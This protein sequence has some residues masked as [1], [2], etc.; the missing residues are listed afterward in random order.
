MHFKLRPTLRHAL[1]AIM[2]P[3]AVAP[4]VTGCTDEYIYDD[5]A[6][7][8]LGESIY[9]ELQ[10]R[11]SFNTMLRLIEDLGY[12]EVLSKTGSKTLFVATDDAFE[13]FFRRNPFG[14]SSYEDLSSAQKRLIMNTSMINMAYLSD[15]LANVANTTGADGAGEGLALR[16]YTSGSYLD[17]ITTVKPKDLINTSYWQRFGSKPLFLCQEF[18]MMT[19]YTPQFML[20]SNMSGSDFETIYGTSYEQGKLYVGN[21]KVAQTDIICKNGY[22]HVMDEVLLPTST[23]AQVIDQ[24]SDTQI[25]KNILDKFCA[26]YYD[27]AKD[28]AIKEYYDGSS[29]MRQP[30]SGLGAN[31]TVFTKRYF[32]E[33]D[34]A[35]A[36][37]GESLS[38]YGL[39]YYDPNNPTY[40]SRG[41]EQDMGVFFVPSDAAMEAYFNGSE[42][43]YLR[44]SYGSWDNVPT[45]ILAMF[46]KNHQKKSFISSLPH[47]WD[48]ITDETSYALNISKQNIERVIPANNG[49]VFILD[50]V[51]PP[52][53]YKGVYASTLTADNTQV[54]KWAITD[55]WSDL[56]DSQAMR[57]YMYL[58][59][60]E[61][62]YNLLVPTDEA[63]HNYRDPI[64]WALGGSN[65]EI[66]DMYYSNVYNRV[67]ADVYPADAEGNVAGGRRRTITDKTIIRNRLRDIIDMHIIVGENENNVLSGYV[68]DGSSQFFLTKGGATIGVAGKG[69]R[70]SFYGGGEMEI[71]VPN[72]QVTSTDGRACIY[73]SQNG[74]T[75]FIDRMLHDPSKNVYDVLG[76][77]P[78]FQEFFDLCRGEGLVSSIFESDPDYEDIFSTK[79]TDSSSA[80]GNVVNSFNNFRY[81]VLVPTNEAIKQ[82]FASD[83]KLYTWEEIALDANI[84]SKKSKALY[85]LKFLRYHFVDNSAY[86]SGVNYGPLK[87]ETSARNSYDKF[88]KVSIQSDGHDLIVTDEQGNVAKVVKGNG[89][90]NI[91]ARDLI[92]NNKDNAAATQITSSSRAVIHQ[93]DRVLNYKD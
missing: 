34:N 21:V 65:R 75:F 85:L 66:W 79:L 88:H 18:P 27:A 76:D 39:L 13:K 20:T 5:K 44:D 53:D 37:T 70:V 71:G 4:I 83:P 87:Y 77:H 62:M 23:M 30:I 84:D 24:Q 48:N 9:A 40:S 29:P 3:A 2:L 46:V 68:D 31:D 22:I 93:I 51:L 17:S 15:M 81:T 7:D 73:D 60:M 61:N 63:F 38:R 41:A 78:E 91:M 82:A 11:G 54:M 36:P 35:S 52:I 72:A 19:H 32:N 45:D 74:R 64:S 28:K 89:L 58:R 69:E 59:S 92:V 42:G 43:G 50:K 16:R 12:K 8:N 1:V 86:V 6:P 25:F 26:P 55:D 67:V 10:S 49:I 57:F 33:I 14:A 47:L 80:I 56:G 90:Y